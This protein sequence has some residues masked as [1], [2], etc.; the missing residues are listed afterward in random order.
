MVGEDKAPSGNHHG[1]CVSTPQSHLVCTFWLIKN[2]MQEGYLSLEEKYNGLV[3]QSI[4]RYFP[5][6]NYTHS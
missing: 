1:V 2:E 5:F 4:A 3:L 6:F